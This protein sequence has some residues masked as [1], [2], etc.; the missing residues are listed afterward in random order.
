[1]VLSLGLAKLRPLK[2][3][4]NSDK[5]RAGSDLR[6][7]QASPD[8]RP[9]IEDEDEDEKEGKHSMSNFEYRQDACAT[10]GTG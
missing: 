7:E 9:Q 2:A 4:L 6:R 3:A 10:L 8:A 5:S 1:V